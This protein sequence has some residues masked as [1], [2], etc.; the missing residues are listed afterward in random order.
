MDLEALETRWASH[1]HCNE[2][3]K[4]TPANSK[5]IRHARHWI[6]SF[7]ITVLTRC[8]CN[9]INGKFKDTYEPHCFQGEKKYT[10]AGEK[11]LRILEEAPTWSNESMSLIFKYLCPGVLRQHG[12]V[13]SALK[14][15]H[16]QNQ[17]RRALT[18]LRIIQNEEVFTH[19]TMTL[20]M[21]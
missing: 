8:L 21:R 15:D 2:K 10:V 14:Q 5:Y 17:I 11:N 1:I 6:G 9:V 7:A 12:F 13:N 18:Q 3:G 16:K 19:K 20:H 4:D